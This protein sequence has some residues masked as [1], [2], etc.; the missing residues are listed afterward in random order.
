M[1][2]WYL[3]SFGEAEVINDN[4]DAIEDVLEIIAG[5]PIS[6]N[7]HSNYIWTSSQYSNAKVHIISMQQ[8]NNSSWHNKF[9][10]S[11]GNYRIKVLPICQL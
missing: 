11:S 5:D 8:I 7:Q 3:P 10:C 6:R 9:S 2:E 4:F 1:G